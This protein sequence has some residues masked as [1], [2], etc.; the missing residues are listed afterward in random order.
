MNHL[1]GPLE[2]M[3]LV[4]LPAGGISNLY[5][6]PLIGQYEADAGQLLQIAASGVTQLVQRLTTG[7][8]I[9]IQGVPGPLP[10]CL[11]R[12]L[13]DLRRRLADLP[14]LLIPEQ[15]QRPGDNCKCGCI[16]REGPDDGGVEAPEEA[17]VALGAH[18]LAVAV[19]GSGVSALGV[20][21]QPGLDDVH[22]VGDDPGGGPGQTTGQQHVPRGDLVIGAGQGLVG[23]EVDAVAGGLAEQGDAQAAEDAPEALGPVDLAQALHGSGVA[24]LLAAAGGHLELQPRLGQL[25]GAADRSLGYTCRGT[26]EEVSGEVALAVAEELLCLAV[27]AEDD[28]VDHRDARHRRG[29]ATV[30]PQRLF[31]GVAFYFCNLIVSF[32]QADFDLSEFKLEMISYDYLCLVMSSGNL[33]I[34]IFNYG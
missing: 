31:G 10:E 5:G 32:D 33:L 30:E 34:I 26:R 21:L 11:A 7:L 16:G 27:D 1:P 24:L 23:E 14:G 3:R 19:Q 28:G 12:L 13:V 15:P 6:R 22:G 17:G 25:D 20:G 9:T 2:M 4:E 18:G 8:A 29:H